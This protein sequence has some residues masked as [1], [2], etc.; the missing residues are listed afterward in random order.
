[1]CEK[2]LNRQ[3]STCGERNGGVRS[4]GSREM[5]FPVA[6]WLLRGVTDPDK[7]LP[8]GYTQT[9][10][11]SAF[12]S[13]HTLRVG[14]A[15]SIPPHPHKPAFNSGKSFSFLNHPL[16]QNKLGFISQMPVFL[17]PI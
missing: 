10:S 11:T 15:N 14:L 4:C 12:S 6:G 7:T 9:N 16:S 2:G 5:C 17:F 1:M 8:H 13:P 3:G